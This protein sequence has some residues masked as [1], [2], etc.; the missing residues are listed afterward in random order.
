M[1][2]FL[3]LVLLFIITGFGSSRAMC[4]EIYKWVDENG[5]VH[6]GSSPP[7]EVYKKKEFETVDNVAAS[8]PDELYETSNSDINGN[9]YTTIDGRSTRRAQFK[10]GKFKFEDLLFTNGRRGT[11]LVASGS[12]KKINRSI[13]LVYFES[14]AELSKV[15]TTELFE[16]HSLNGKLMELLTA[17]EQLWRMKKL[18]TSRPTQFSTDIRGKWR[19][20]TGEE[21]DFYHGIF[22]IRRPIPQSGN[23][24]WRDSELV[25]DFVVNLGRPIDHSSAKR[26]R[27][28]I[29]EKSYQKIEI[30]EIGSEEEITLTR[31]R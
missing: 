16:V 15:D 2:K 10:N 17:E 18:E 3:P 6:Y 1:K 21:F 30:V 22:H 5:R 9:W 25:L 27:W 20:S 23:W 26:V 19:S 4:A 8:D 29:K 28:E 13:E 31:I 11:R 24:T 14:P 12:F 7:P